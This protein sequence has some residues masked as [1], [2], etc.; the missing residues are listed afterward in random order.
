M[1]LRR[2]MNRTQVKELDPILLR[3]WCTFTVDR[4]KL[5]TDCSE[6]FWV[7]N[8]AGKGRYS[9]WLSLN[10]SSPSYRCVLLIMSEFCLH[11][12]TSLLASGGYL[13][14]RYWLLYCL[15]MFYL[16]MIIDLLLFKVQLRHFNFCCVFPKCLKFGRN[17]TLKLIQKR[18][19]YGVHKNFYLLTILV[20]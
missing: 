15:K 3:I 2:K 16:T 18:K 20:Q 19:V 5:F 8:H 1:K 6:T 12:E 7:E 13:S 9:G 17:T 11:L 14:V 10:A 4:V